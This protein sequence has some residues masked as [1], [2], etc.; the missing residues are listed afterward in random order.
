MKEKKENKPYIWVAMKSGKKR[1]SY[2]VVIGTL[3]R[4]GTKG[5]DTLRLCFSLPPPP[6]LLSALNSGSLSAAPSA[7][8]F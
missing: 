2:P 4:K 1:T 6:P 8:S 5:S 3:R 7:M